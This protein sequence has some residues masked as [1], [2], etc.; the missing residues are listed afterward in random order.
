[1]KINWE[2]D[3]CF[4]VRVAYVFISYSAN[5]GFSMASMEKSGQK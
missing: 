5:K 4:Y 3:K 2:E 1:M